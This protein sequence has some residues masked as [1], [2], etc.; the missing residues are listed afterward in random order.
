M[1]LSLRLFLS[2]RGSDL[3]FLGTGDLL[4]ERLRL[5]SLLGLLLLRR[6]SLSRLLHTH[7]CASAHV[8]AC[9]MHST[10]A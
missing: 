4:S 7:S 9:L 1:L 2:L 8:A 10:Y 5:C 3:C 6:L